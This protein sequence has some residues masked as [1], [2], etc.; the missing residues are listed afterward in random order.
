MTAV[1]RTLRTTSLL[2]IVVVASLGIR[3]A[4]D[5]TRTLS[6]Q[7]VGSG[8]G[9]GDSGNGKNNGTG[10]DGKDFTIEGS[11]TGLFPGA[12]TQLT[13]RVRN[14]NN[15]P[16][17]VRTLRATPSAA[18]ACPASNL[19]ISSFTGSLDVARNGTATRQLRVR[20]IG[21]SPN[22][23]KGALQALTYTGTADKK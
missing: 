21:D 10:N 17:V 23:C 18:G 7:L 20:V 8:G 2:L 5:G 9:L 19:L 14:S 3:S 15:F 22:A 13:L 6:T 12:D 1:T 16:I 11:V 4:S